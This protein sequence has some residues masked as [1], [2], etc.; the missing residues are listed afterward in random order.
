[1]ILTKKEANKR[2]LNFGRICTFHYNY[3]DQSGIYSCDSCVIVR[4]PCGCDWDMY[5]ED[6]GKKI[7]R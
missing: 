1:M 5:C 4:D 7:K 6:C 3:P 2:N